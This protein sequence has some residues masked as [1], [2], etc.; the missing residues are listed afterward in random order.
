MLS[1]IPRSQPRLTSVS[2]AAVVG[3]SYL[4]D[5]KRYQDEFVQA[6]GVISACLFPKRPLSQTARCFVPGRV[7][8]V[9]GSKKTAG[10]PYLKAHDAFELRPETTRYLVERRMASAEQ[11]RLSRGQILTPSSGRNLGPVVYVGSYLSRFAMTDIMR[12][13]P[14]KEEDGHYLFAYLLTDTA[15]ALLRRGRTGT[16][17]DHL[18]PNEVEALDVVWPDEAIRNR[19]ASLV[20]RAERLLD[21]ARFDLDECETRLHDAAGLSLEPHAGNYIS[22]AVRA[23]GESAKHLAMRVDAAFYDP[24]VQMARRALLDR[25]HSRLDA[26][27]QLRMLGRYKRYYVDEPHGR[28]I[29]SGR[30]MLQIRPV[31]LKRIS[32]RSFA[33]PSAF[34]LHEGWSIFTCDGR[35][36]EA[37]GEPSFVTARIDGWMASNHVMRAIALPGVHPGFLHCLLRSP[38]VQVQLKAT[39]TG[40][41]ID[42]LDPDTAG[43]VLVPRVD[44]ALETELG[45]KVVQA[46]RNIDSYY[47]LIEEAVTLVND[48]LKS[49]SGGVLGADQK[50]VA[51]G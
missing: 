50:L 43:A 21:D 49:R 8:L 6:Q 18:A 37:L 24:R 16:T 25:P 51:T 23:F 2:A 14:F 42:A 15:Q 5:A 35:S 9:T 39:A 38:Y 45:E 11:L 3:P 48:C 26:A 28:P 46:W 1:D 31:A 22:S 17:V 34:I 27:C 41:V 36:E 44:S 32:D 40:S 7:K 20:A 33:D 12:I 47:G 13:C 19:V 29:L 30:Q 4:L 10:D